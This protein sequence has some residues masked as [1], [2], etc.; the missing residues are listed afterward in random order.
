M[1]TVFIYQHKQKQLSDHVLVE[2]PCRCV[3]SIKDSFIS[4]CSVTLTVY[5]TQPSSTGSRRSLCRL[6][7][8]I[9]PLGSSYR[10]SALIIWWTWNSIW[11]SQLHNEALWLLNVLICCNTFIRAR[12]L[13]CWGRRFKSHWRDEV[14]KCQVQTCQRSLLQ[15]R[16]L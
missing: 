14:L 10:L 2:K 13:L 16:R 15:F 12:R 7:P 8:Q 11:Y 6:R 9:F 3:S 1:E 4:L 5:R